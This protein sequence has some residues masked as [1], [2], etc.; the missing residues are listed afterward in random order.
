[1]KSREWK[2]Q[3][4]QLPHPLQVDFYDVLKNCENV[5]TMYYQTQTY[6][7]GVNCFHK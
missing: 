7:K 4:L 2:C 5:C 3:E 6:R 1:M